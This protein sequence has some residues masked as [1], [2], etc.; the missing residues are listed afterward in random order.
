MIWGIRT[1]IKKTGS[2]LVQKSI[3]KRRSKTMADK[4]KPAKPAPKKK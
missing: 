2:K 1:V 3:V 4:K